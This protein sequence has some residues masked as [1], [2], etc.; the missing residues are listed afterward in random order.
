MCVPLNPYTMC[1][2]T[3]KLQP[4]LIKQYVYS[5]TYL[6]AMDQTAMDSLH[7]VC[8]ATRCKLWELLVLG[9]FFCGRCRNFTAYSQENHREQRKADSIRQSKQR[10]IKRELGGWKMTPSNLSRYACM[11]EKKKNPFQ[12]SP[13]K[14]APLNTPPGLVHPMAACQSP[15]QQ[16]SLII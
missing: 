16:I 2:N 14:P 1:T 6:T 11:Q 15:L 3:N 9:L 13:L 5:D 12:N 4:C 10:L 8:R 7:K